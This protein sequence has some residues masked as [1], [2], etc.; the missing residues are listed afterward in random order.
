MNTMPAR[1]AVGMS[2]SRL[3]RNSTNSR[4]TAAMVMLATWVRP[5]WPSRISVLVGLPLTTKVPDRPAAKLAPLRPTRSRLMSTRS[6]CLAAKLR[7]V[8]ALWATMRTKQAKAIE[9]A[10][11]T[12]FHPKPPG[13]PI[14]GKPPS[15]EPT[16]AD[17]VRL[18]VG[19]GRD[20]DRQDDRDH[21]PGHDRQELLEADDQA[22][23]AEREGHGGAAGIGDRG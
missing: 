21:G 16:T 13:R 17:A 8:A 5:F 4:A 15:R 3:V 6:P 19:R 12:S 20:D 18:G 10:L 22:H 7:E 9:A 23:R 1:T 11:T 14:G 2:V